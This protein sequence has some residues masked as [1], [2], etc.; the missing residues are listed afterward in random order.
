MIKFSSVCSHVLRGVEWQIS[1][2]KHILLYRALGWEPPEFA[3]LP[4]LLNSDG[5]KLSKRQNDLQIRALR[6]NLYF[7][8][9][10]LNLVTLV[11]GGFQDKDYSLRDLYSLKE[12]IEKFEMGRIHIS[13]GKIEMDRLGELNQSCI[14]TRLKNKELRQELIQLCRRTVTENIEDVEPRYLTD[15]VIL[16]YLTWAQDRIKNI[17]ELVS[18][19]YVYLWKAPKISQNVTINKKQVNVILKLIDQSEDF[20]S[21]MKDLQL[22][23]DEGMKVSVLMKDLRTILTGRQQGPPLKELLNNL[24]KEETIHRLSGFK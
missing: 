4:L 20:S 11:G 21:I 12:L 9:S 2:P 23:K 15:D 3:H 24:G 10:V 1:T 5:T 19:E 8:E 7:P 14:Q 6:D 16:K 18:P 17:K 13:P 22:F